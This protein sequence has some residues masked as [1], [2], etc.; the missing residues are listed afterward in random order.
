MATSLTVAPDCCAQASMI[1]CWD[2]TRSAMSSVVQTVSALSSAAPPAFSPPPPSPPPPQPA[3]T[4]MAVR[5]APASKRDLHNFLLLQA[6]DAFSSG[7]G[8]QRSEE[9]RH[10]QH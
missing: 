10:F 6:T 3:T 4:S 5:A 7:P 1:F 9:A 2:A 8:G